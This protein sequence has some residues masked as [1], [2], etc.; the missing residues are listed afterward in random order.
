MADHTSAL[1]LLWGQVTLRGSRGLC[2]PLHFSWFSQEFWG[3][4]HEVCMVPGPLRKGSYHIQEKVGRV[5]KGFAATCSSAQPRQD[6]EEGRKGP[7]GGCGIR[8]T[9]KNQSQKSIG[10]TADLLLAK[11]NDV[12]R[13]LASQVPESQRRRRW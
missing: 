3:R 11:I 2:I 1:G 7:A 10:L 5:E 13:P 8:G 4:G 12:E 9:L 6:K